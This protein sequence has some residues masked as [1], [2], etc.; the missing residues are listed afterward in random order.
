M[1][2]SEE[3]LELCTFMGAEAQI[4]FWHHSTR[5]PRADSLMASLSAQTTLDQQKLALYTCEC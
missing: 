2:N 4:L 5:P 3:S 1:Q